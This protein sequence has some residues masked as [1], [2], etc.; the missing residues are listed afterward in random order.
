MHSETERIFRVLESY[1]ANLPDVQKFWNNL[2][3]WNSEE[4]GKFN[5]W[6]FLVSEG[7]V[8]STVQSTKIDRAIQ[9]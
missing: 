8:Y 3:L 6:K 2:F 7:F 1:N 9:H 5:I 4:Q